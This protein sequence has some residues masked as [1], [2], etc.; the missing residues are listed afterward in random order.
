M[1]VDYV[2]LVCTVLVFYS[3]LRGLSRSHDSSYRSPLIKKVGVFVDK[4]DLLDG[5]LYFRKITYP[6]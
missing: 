2:L 4:E 1:S 3:A 6:Y 5:I